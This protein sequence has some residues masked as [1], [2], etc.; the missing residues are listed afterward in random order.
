METKE[1]CTEGVSTMVEGCEE[2]HEG[3]IS[4]GGL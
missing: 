1:V 3:R 4:E 2:G